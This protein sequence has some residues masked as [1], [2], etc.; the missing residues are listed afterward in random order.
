MEDFIINSAGELKAF[1]AEM[2]AQ[3]G[4]A[5]E[6]LYGVLI[7]QQIVSGIAGI[8]TWV[9]MLLFWMW[10]LRHFRVSFYGYMEHMYEHD[11]F[12]YSAPTWIYGFLTFGFGIAL[13]ITFFTLFMPSIQHLINPEYYALQDIFN[14]IKGPVTK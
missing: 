11:D 9:F 2:A 14:F 8:L 5:A 1:I 3:L 12:K 4:V 6:H 10:V 7:R 13:I